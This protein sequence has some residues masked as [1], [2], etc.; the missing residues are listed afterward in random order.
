MLLL[1]KK[2]VLCVL[3]Y[4]LSGMVF[5]EDLPR[6]GEKE[7]L[8]GRKQSKAVESFIWNITVL[9]V[10][11]V[12]FF[13]LKFCLPNLSFLTLWKYNV[14]SCS[15]SIFKC[16]HIFLVESMWKTISFRK[17]LGFS[18]FL[19]WFINNSSNT[20]FFVAFILLLLA[21]VSIQNVYSSVSLVYFF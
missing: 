13:V 15:S 16:L 18:N 21:A 17:T 9:K 4:A 5:H 14:I 1:R 8:K 19:H 7:N 6:L 3:C 10:N 2:Q 20:T 11:S 12:S